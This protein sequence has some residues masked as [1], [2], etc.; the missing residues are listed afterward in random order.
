LIQKFSI[1]NKKSFG[2]EEGTQRKFSS[3]QSA[4][5]MLEE[6]PRLLENSFPHFE[7]KINSS[8]GGKGRKMKLN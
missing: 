2:R 1:F 3:P 6:C 8:R 5:F 7:L 4:G